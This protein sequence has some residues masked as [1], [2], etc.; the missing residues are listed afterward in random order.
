MDNVPLP[1]RAR[2]PRTT[3]SLRAGAAH[4]PKLLV[5]V[6]D[7]LEARLA[8]NAG[9]DWIDLKNPD[10]G[11]LGAPTVKTAARV[12]KELA[13]FA[14]RSV[15]LGELQQIDFSAAADLSRWFPILKVGLSGLRDHPSWQT[16]LGE[17]SRL[18]AGNARLV[19][20]IYAD[21]RLCE[22]PEPEAVLTAADAIDAPFVLIDTYTKDGRGLFAWLSESEIQH[23]VVA[24]NSSGRQLVV[25]GSLAE[26]DLPKLMPLTISAIAVRGALCQHDRRGRLCSEKLDHWVDIFRLHS[27]SS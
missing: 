14:C 16:T 1:S 15:A 22:A 27:L 21:H 20:V 5:S 3:D 26:S 12:A 9:V 8:R 24:T 7:D 18:L 2:S 10:A 23:L 25:A 13:D 4:S 6:Q 17:L 19:P 11:P